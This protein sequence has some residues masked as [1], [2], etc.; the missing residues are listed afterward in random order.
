LFALGF[1]GSILDKGGETGYIDL[2]NIP[3]DRA[4]Y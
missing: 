1:F 4:A 2:L 3:G